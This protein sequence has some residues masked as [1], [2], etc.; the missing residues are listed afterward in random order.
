MQ[1]GREP[2]LTDRFWLGR[3]IHRIVPFSESSKLSRRTPPSLLLRI[4][5]PGGCLFGTKRFRS[6]KGSRLFLYEGKL[7][8]IPDTYSKAASFLKS[9]HALSSFSL[10]FLWADDLFEGFLGARSL[11]FLQIT[12]DWKPSSPA[13]PLLL[14]WVIAFATHNSHRTSFFWE[15]SRLTKSPSQLLRSW[16]VVIS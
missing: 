6:I 16:L 5:T 11:V 3:F 8:K 10:L 12:R 2:S 4:R 1:K 7:D 14:S 15:M 13:T 9:F